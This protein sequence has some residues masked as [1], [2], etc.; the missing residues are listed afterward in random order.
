MNEMIGET[1]RTV[2]TKTGTEETETTEIVVTIVIVEIDIGI[3]TRGT[4]IETM[5][6]MIDGEEEEDLIIEERGE[7]VI[8]AGIG[9]VGTVIVEHQ[10]GIKTTLRIVMKTSQLPMINLGTNPTTVTTIPIPMT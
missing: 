8:I 5:R 1:T 4:E 7:G 9:I 3:E 10:D 2:E 6:E